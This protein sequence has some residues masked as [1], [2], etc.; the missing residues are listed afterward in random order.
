LDILEDLKKELEER[1]KEIG[2]K[3]PKIERVVIESISV[4]RTAWKGERPY[5]GVRMEI[6][7]KMSERNRSI[8]RDYKA[9]ERV[10]FLVR[11]YG[12]TRQRIN[13]IIKG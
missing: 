1:L 6:D 4:V 3:D 11:R 8:I 2:F 12:L 13:Q 9:G 10:N 5:I 7:K